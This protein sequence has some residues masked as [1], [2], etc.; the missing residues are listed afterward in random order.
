RVAFEVHELSLGGLG[1]AALARS[2]TAHELA[3]YA[4]LI[5]EDGTRGRPAHR[6]ADRYVA[7]GFVQRHKDALAYNREQNRPEGRE[8]FTDDQ[9]AEFKQARDQAV[10]EF[11][12]SI[13]TQYGWAAPLF[14]ESRRIQF[15]DL[16][17]AAGAGVMRSHYLWAN[18]E[19]HADSWGAV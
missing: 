5:G 19:V 18:H 6:L 17:E 12:Q 15:P 16:E 1:K 13:K 7:F 4:T 14:Q 3:T 8:P 10:Q 9:M 2:R 11:G